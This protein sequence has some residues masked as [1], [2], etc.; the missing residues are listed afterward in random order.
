[1]KKMSIFA[2]VLAGVVVVTA[3]VR[4]IQDLE[5]RGSHLD[6]FA[7]ASVLAWSLIP[8][9]FSLLGALIVSR[10]PG[11]LVG[12]LLFLPALIYLP[13]PGE[14]YILTFA[15][16]PSNPPAK[17]LLAM[18]FST[19]GWLLLIFPLLFIPVLFPT[20][21]PPSPRWRWVLIA[22]LGMCAL[23]LLLA[24]FSNSFSTVDYGLDWSIAN[25]IGFISVGDKFWT[26]F[27]LPWT[28]G[29]MAL[30]LLS[31][32]S[33]FVRYRRAAAIERQ[34]IKWL[35]YACGLFAAFYVGMG[36]ANV[37][38]PETSANTSAVA[39]T[40]FALSIL[41]IP[42]A[43]AIA[44]LRYRLWDIDVIIRRTL[45]Y[46][47]LTVTL[48][49]VYFGLV[50]LLQAII[51]S[52]SNQQSPISNVLSTLAIAALFTPLRK[53]IQSDIDRRFFRKK[54]DAQKTLDAFA[55][56]ARD[57]VELE[58]LTGYLVEVVQETMQP[59]MVDIWLKEDR[60]P[61]Q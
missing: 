61:R 6:F 43:I 23:F 16:A 3:I 2:W 60:K 36:I 38:N 19:W 7:L 50:T 57:E 28:I 22:G 26:Y 35:L 40:L 45:V 17:L 18:W 11:N 37:I 52:I 5:N 41:A 9:V 30:T 14:E 59:Q 27:S 15:S 13:F 39:D 46:G 54:Y 33:L 51:S 44:I 20:G 49:T 53:R 25:P 24:T 31:V 48:A 4:T 42:A 8:V 58:K 55:A 1:M 21:R 29:L 34:Q 32:S 56:R 47:A 12:W 10:Q